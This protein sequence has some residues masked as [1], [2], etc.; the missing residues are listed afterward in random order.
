MYF[1]PREWKA[2]N[3]RFGEILFFLPYLAAS[4]CI[5]FFPVL[6]SLILFSYDPTHSS[7]F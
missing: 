5:L 6:F 7:P 2:I 1:L 3:S 4:F